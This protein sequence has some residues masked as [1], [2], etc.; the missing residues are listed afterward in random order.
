MLTT[1]FPS[2]RTQRCMQ[3]VHF[4]GFRDLLVFQNDNE[5]QLPMT[6][7]KLYVDLNSLPCH[8]NNIDFD[9]THQN[10]HQNGN[11]SKIIRWINN[12]KHSS[13]CVWTTII[14]DAMAHAVHNKWFVKFASFFVDLVAQKCPAAQNWRESCCATPPHGNTPPTKSLWTLALARDPWQ[15]SNGKADILRTKHC[16]LLKFWMILY[17]M[18]L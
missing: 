9:N 14:D 4:G 2:P 16:K 17:H 3:H 7:V 1:K 18:V 8:A 10:W 15:P 11:Q 12:T 5:G 13:H 6:T